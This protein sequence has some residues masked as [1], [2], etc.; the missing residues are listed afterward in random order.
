MFTQ[1]PSTTITS[2]SLSFL[3]LSPT[4]PQSILGIVVLPLWVLQS[5]T[6]IYNVLKFILIVHEMYRLMKSLASYA[7]L[8]PWTQIKNPTGSSSCPFCVCAEKK[9]KS[10]VRAQFVSEN[11]KHNGLDRAVNSSKKRHVGYFNWLLSSNINNLLTL[12]QLFKAAYKW[13]I[14]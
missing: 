4:F 3:S 5:Y 8:W 13:Q 10:G 11:G 6:S 9:Y 7:V 1:S 14:I 12:N 2:I